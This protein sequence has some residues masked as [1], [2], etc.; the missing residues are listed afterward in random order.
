MT[1]TM[2]EEVNCGGSIIGKKDTI[3][4]LWFELQS[5]PAKIRIKDDTLL[6][7]EKAQQIISTAKEALEKAKKCDA[8]FYK[9]QQLEK[10]I[11]RFEDKVNAVSTTNYAGSNYYKMLPDLATDLLIND[12]NRIANSVHIIGYGLI[13][14]EEGYAGCE[15][16]RGDSLSEVNRGAL[17][18][19]EGVS[20]NLGRLRE[21]GTSIEHLM[22]KHHNSIRFTEEEDGYGIR[23][24]YVE[25]GDDNWEDRQDCV[26]G[27]MKDR[28]G[29]RCEPGDGLL[30]KCQGILRSSQDI[31]E[32]AYFMGSLSDVDL[33]TSSCIEAACT[34][35]KENAK[36]IVVENK[37]ESYRVMPYPSEASSWNEKVCDIPAEEQQ[38]RR[39]LEHWESEFRFWKERAEARRKATESYKCD[40]MVYF[41]AL[42][43]DESADNMESTC[44]RLAGLSDYAGY[45]STQSDEARELNEEAFKALV[46]RCRPEAI[47]N[48]VEATKPDFA[49]LINVLDPFDVVCRIAQ[50]E[51]C[52]KE[53]SRAHARE[54]E[55]AQQSLLPFWKNNPSF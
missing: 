31:R 35:A 41:E 21:G 22:G 34:Y 4:R 51:E 2:V 24:E 50:D 1:L 25:S 10:L 7:Q 38:E 29:I 13:P 54:K 8:P 28:F 18:Y 19:C 55:Q 6:N 27:H 36:E 45:C 20:R 49:T 47:I 42:M 5:Y 23:M 39:E 30:S 52:L 15:M 37:E 9:I 3:H 11:K 48:Q 12:I 46:K 44:R 33:L 53:I 43:A 16:S 32:L 17:S 26:T 14:T 40:T